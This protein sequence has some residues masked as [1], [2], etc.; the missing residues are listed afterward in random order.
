LNAASP[1]RR[2]AGPLTRL[3]VLDLALVGTAGAFALL[4]CTAAAV[5]KIGIADLRGPLRVG[6]KGWLILSRG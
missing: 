5:A 6:C 1:R 4:V 3:R 2:D